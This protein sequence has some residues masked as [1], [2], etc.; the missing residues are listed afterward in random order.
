MSEKKKKLNTKPLNNYIKF[1]GYV[2]QMA[3]TIVVFVLV[4]KYIDNRMGHEK[5]VVTAILSVIGVLLSL[6]NLYRSVKNVK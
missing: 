1:S 6:Y 3:A 4:G 5:L 2:F